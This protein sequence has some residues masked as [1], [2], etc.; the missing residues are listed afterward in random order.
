MAEFR[1]VAGFIHVPLPFL[2]ARRKADIVKIT[3]SSEMDPWRLKLSTIDL[4]PDGSP[5]SL[6]PR[7]AF[8]QSKMASVVIFR[9]PSVPYGK[10]LRH[11]FF[12]YLAGEKV[13]A[14]STA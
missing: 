4:L 13:L 2:A 10:A 14:R 6:N 3:E 11:E 5:K 9:Q 8:G 12:N 7:H 1:L